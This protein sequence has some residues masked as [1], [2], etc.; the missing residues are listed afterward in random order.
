MLEDPKYTLVKK[1]DS[2]LMRFIS[3]LL[4]WQKKVFMENYITTIGRTIYWPSTVP[5]QESVLKHELQHIRDYNKWKILFSLSYLFFP[6]PAF[7]T[8]RAHWERKAYKIS[9]QYWVKENPTNTDWIVGFLQQQ[10]CTSRYLWMWPSK[11]A[12]EKWAQAC[13]KENLKV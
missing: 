1:E 4:F 12:V 5:M 7:W 8:M 2:K 13:I 10:F 6:L 11:K 3:V 9:I